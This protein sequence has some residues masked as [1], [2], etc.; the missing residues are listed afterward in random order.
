MASRYLIPGRTWGI[1]VHFPWCIQKCPYCDF[2]SVPAEPR[3]IPQKTYTEAVLRELR[4]R[5]E[6]LGPLTAHSLF[7]GGG[8]PSLW[9]PEQLGRVIAGVR[10]SFE[11][12]QE[13]EVTVECNP[14]SFDRDKALQLI[15]AGVNRVSIGVQSLAQAQLEFLGRWHDGNEAIRAV[16]DAVQAGVPRVSA[17]LIYGVFGQGPEQAQQEV[18]RV[19]ELGISHLSAYT[20]TIEPGTRFGQRKRKGSLPLLEESLVAES[21]NAVHDALERSGFEHYEI[22]N[23]AREGHQSRHNLGYWLGQPYLGLGCGAWG[24]LPTN[25]RGVSLRYRNLA[26][27]ERYMA[28]NHWPLPTD[29][30]QTQKDNSCTVENLSPE[31]QL[32]ERLMLGLRLQEGLDMVATQHELDLDVM[33]AK[34]AKVVDRL[35]QQGNLEVVSGHWR[36]PQERWLHADGIISQLI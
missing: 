22:S 36:I 28:S 35:Q 17:D 6:S 34:R 30:S 33:T 21:Y 14:S 16:Q 4:C 23:F 1:Y 24:T 20:L 7:F 11:Q 3:D 8:T 26:S 25:E 2:L 29:V 19:A 10:E 5:A 32:T 27:P 13:L 15:D 31:T 9:D 12:T 18:Q